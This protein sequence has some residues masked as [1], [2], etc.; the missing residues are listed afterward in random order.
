MGNGVLNINIFLSISRYFLQLTNS[1]SGLFPV[2]VGTLYLI[3]VTKVVN[4]GQ[5][6]YS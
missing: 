5:G 3:N 4:R 2:N 6:S 1:F